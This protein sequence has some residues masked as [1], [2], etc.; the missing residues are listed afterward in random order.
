MDVSQEQVDELVSF[1]MR[2]WPNCCYI[3][4]DGKVRIVSFIPD[5]TIEQM[6][7]DAQVLYEAVKQ[8]KLQMGKLSDLGIDASHRLP[9]DDCYVPCEL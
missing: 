9:S 7:D 5:V 6:P 8:K 3:V 4:E 2:C 1:L